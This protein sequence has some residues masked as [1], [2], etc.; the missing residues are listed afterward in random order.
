MIKHYINSI[1]RLMRQFGVKKHAKRV[2]QWLWFILLW[3]A[4]LMIVLVLAYSIRLVMG[5]G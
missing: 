3:S 1:I 2:S 4:S 5:V